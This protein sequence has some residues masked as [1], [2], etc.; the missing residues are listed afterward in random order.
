[1]SLSKF[2]ALPDL[3][4]KIET[5]RK[6]N[7]KIAL[8]NGDFYLIHTGYTRFLREAKK[9][10]DILVAALPSDRSLKKIKGDKEPLIDEKGRIKMIASFECVDYVTFFDGPTL[11]RVRVT[12]KPDFYCIKPADL[13]G[14]VSENE[15]I[16][17]KIIVLSGCDKPSISAILKKI[18]SSTA[19]MENR[20]NEN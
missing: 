1:M 11:D 10:A 20:R 2:F 4:E 3:K 12:I 19:H 8:I 9:T 15:N 17:G 13:Q 6:Q 14:P 18:A 7:E 16:P 5:E